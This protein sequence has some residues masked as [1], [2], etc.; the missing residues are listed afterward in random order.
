VEAWAL[1]AEESVLEGLE[2]SVKAATE[3][4]EAME[5]E[6]MVE[7]AC[8]DNLSRSCTLSQGRY[9]NDHQKARHS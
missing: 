3:E 8:Q 6:A 9:C 7:L 4:T 2:A 5:T 1:V